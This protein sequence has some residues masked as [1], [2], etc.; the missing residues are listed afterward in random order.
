MDKSN[1]DGWV[2]IGTKIDDTEFK[3]D[4]KVLEMRLKRYQKEGEQL[5][6]LKTGHESKIDEL[7]SEIDKYN[8]LR[9]QYDY[10]IKAIDLINEK[11]KELKSQGISEQDFPAQ[12]QDFMGKEYQRRKSDVLEQMVDMQAPNVLTPQLEAEKRALDDVNSKLRENEEQQRIIGEQID[13]NVQKVNKVKQANEEVQNK[14]KSIEETHKKINSGIQQ[15]GKG[16]TNTIAKVGRW[17]IAVIGVYS[18][19]SMVRQAMNTLAQYDKTLASDLEYIRFA[20]ATALKPVVEFIVDLIYR[21]LQYTRYLL[22]EW[23]NIDIFAKASVNHFKKAKES[24]NKSAKSAKEIKKQLAGFDEMNILVDTRTKDKDDFD[25][26]PPSNDLTKNLGGDVPKWLEWL[27]ENKDWILPL[28]AGI[29]GGLL[30]IKLGLDPLQSLGIVGIIAGIIYAIEGL[31]EYMEDPT[32]ENFGQVIQGIGLAFLGLALVIGSPVLAIIGACVL[33]FGTIVK[34]WDKIKDFL[35]GG[36]DWLEGKSDWVHEHFGDIIGD[37]YDTIVEKL[38]NMLDGLDTL[39]TNFKDGFDNL[40]DFVN[41]V[42]AGNWEGAWENVKNIFEDFMENLWTIFKAFV[43][44][45]IDIVEGILGLIF[46][47]IT[48]TKPYPGTGGRAKGG[49]FY[50]SKLPKLALGGII[51]QPGRGVPYNGAIIGERGAE[52]VVPLTDSQQM[53]LL[54][55]TIGK[56]ITINANITNTMNGRVISRELQKVQS[57][58]DFAY[59]R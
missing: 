5:A 42:F 56:Y 30:A 45:M 17:A 40:I 13:E 52:A 58:N 4:M 12:Y 38:Q 53:E 26:T 33:I 21:L 19:Y 25:F 28:L 32:W 10:Y 34:Y 50:P 22:K 41:N 36:I 16:I 23:F 6:E 31:F 8:E 7:Q 57:D 39:F 35:Q 46:P 47:E 54:G 24:L 14:L 59:N 9:K 43:Q 27:A 15:V 18:A 51:N 44:P 3:K 1:V 11:R 20:L 48:V 29:A 55:Q 49:I 2:I 37:I